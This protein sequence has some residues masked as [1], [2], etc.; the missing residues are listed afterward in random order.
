MMDCILWAI[1]HELPNIFDIGLDV[2]KTLLD[3][4]FIKFKLEKKYKNFII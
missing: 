2:L 4:N 3:V 1:K